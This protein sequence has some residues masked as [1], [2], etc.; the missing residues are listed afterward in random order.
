MPR[1]LVVADEPWVRNEV[2]AALTAPDVSLVDHVDPAT[3][4]DTATTD[5]FDAVI[6]DLQVGARGGMAVTRDLLERAALDG[7]QP[8]PAVLLLDRSADAF[9][10]KRAG[11]AGWV[12]KP[13]SSYELVEAMATAAD[14]VSKHAL[15][16]ANDE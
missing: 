3:A 6:C 8:I 16:T 9:L 1:Y 7:T 15:E 10:A 2:H 12:A 4:A 13:F 11:A 14:G 5:A